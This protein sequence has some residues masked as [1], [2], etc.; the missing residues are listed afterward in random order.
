M[1]EDLQSVVNDR[2]NILNNIWALKVI[3]RHL[4]IKAPIIDNEMRLT[5]EQV[6][7][8][9]DVDERTIRRYVEQ[10]ETELWSN[11]YEIFTGKRLQE[12]KEA[13]V[14]DTDVLNINKMSPQIWFFTFRAFLNIGM[15]LRESEV[16][17][18]LR[19]VILD[20]VIEYLNNKWWG[21]TKYINVNDDAYLLAYK[22]SIWYRKKFTDAL[23]NYIDAWN[24]KYPHYTDLVYQAIFMENSREYKLL[25][26][27][28]QTEN[29]RHTLY[30]EVLSVV[31]QYENWFAHYLKEESEKLWRKLTD[32]EAKKLFDTF[33]NN[34]LLEPTREMAR[35]LMA[36]R[37]KA[38]RQI[39]HEKLEPYINSLSQKEYERFCSEFIEYKWEKNKVMLEL[40]NEHKDIFIRLRDK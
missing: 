4:D 7:L 23:H 11:G 34:P 20:I 1:Y 19:K 28:E 18:Q 14:K 16:A 5:T 39:L 33:K 29:L 8:F 25:L 35:M 37:D 21:S 24:F 6:A 13:Y 40:M 2:Q 27:L 26:K 31:S 36:S 17:R 22:D 9:Y 30:S 12:A 3:E 10:N 15:L 32:F 38:L